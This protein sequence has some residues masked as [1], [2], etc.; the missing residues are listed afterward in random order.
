MSSAANDRL[1]TGRAKGRIRYFAISFNKLGL[2]LLLR[3][4][5]TMMRCDDLPAERNLRTATERS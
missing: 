4:V 1:P 2:D 3:S 5:V